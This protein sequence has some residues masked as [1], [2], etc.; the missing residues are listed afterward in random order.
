MSGLIPFNRRRNDLM[1]AGFGDFQNMLD[2]FFSDTWPARRSLASDTFKID[3]QDE[4]NTYLVEAE[5]P[6]VSKEDIRISVDDGKL[7]I[8]VEKNEENEETDK[9]YIH[10][11]RRFCSMS[12]NIFLADM[13]PEEIKAKL[14][15]GILKIEIQKRQAQDVSKYIAI[16]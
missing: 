16:E 14:D 6:G 10:R 3:V 9:H 1:N 11:E 13:N 12:R 15:E 7:N 8:S 2:D 4:E 5:L